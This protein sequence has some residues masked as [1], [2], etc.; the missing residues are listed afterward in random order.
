MT[1]GAPINELV[2]TPGNGAVYPVRMRMCNEHVAEVGCSYSEPKAVQTYGPLRDSYIYAITSQVDGLNV[3]WNISGT[4]NG[5]A[6]VV[7]ISIDGGAEEH[8]AL[9]SPGDFSFTRTVAVA[10]YNTRTN[11]QVRLFDDAPAGRGQ[12]IDYG[13]VETGDPPAPVITIYKRASCLD[14]DVDG[15]GAPI[16]GNDC[17]NT[18]ALGCTDSRCGLLGIQVTGARAVYGCVVREGGDPLFSY[19]YVGNQSGGDTATDWTFKNGRVAVN[20]EAGTGGPNYF[21]VTAYM[22]WP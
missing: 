15:N 17:R 19:P 2:V 6:A 11:I 20:C 14:G 4:S 18:G 3:T 5:D 9:G 22:D 13:Q 7:G 10:D 16:T 21:N 12:G 8:V 1:P